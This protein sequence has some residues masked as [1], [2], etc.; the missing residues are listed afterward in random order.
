MTIQDI[1]EEKLVMAG[2]KDLQMALTL[3]ID[4][5]QIVFLPKIEILV[6]TNQ[7]GVHMS[8]LIESTLIAWLETEK[9]GRV[10]DLGLNI[11]KY[12][13]KR[14]DLIGANPSKITIHCEG[15]YIYELSET[16]TVI[17]YTVKENDKI[18]NTIGVKVRCLSS[19]PCTKEESEGKYTHTQGVNITLMRENGNILDLLRIVEENVTPTRTLLKRNEE[20]ELVKKSYENPLF[21]EDIVRKLSPLADYVY[22]ESEEAIHKHKAVAEIGEK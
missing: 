8:R 12:I 5:Q 21:V 3:M 14:K 22:V 7:K 15:D 1:K 2:I 16:C 11:L 9:Q 10:E 4:K 17:L 6:S 19:C 18:T 20:V 13:L